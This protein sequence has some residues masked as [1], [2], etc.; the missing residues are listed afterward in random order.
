MH[1]SQLTELAVSHKDVILVILKDRVL[2]FTS[3]LPLKIRSMS[4]FD[5]IFISI[6]FIIKD[7]ALWDLRGFL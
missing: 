4:C 6:K 1:L 7:G 5:I 2:F 3:I